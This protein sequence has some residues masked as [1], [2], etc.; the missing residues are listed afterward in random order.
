MAPIK[1]FLLGVFHFW[2]SCK[3]LSVFL[4]PARPEL[5]GYVLYPS[6]LSSTIQS[7]LWNYPGGGMT[8]F[9]FIVKMLAS[10]NGW[11]LLGSF[12]ISTTRGQEFR[13][14]STS[15]ISMRR[16]SLSRLFPCIF[17]IDARITCTEI[18]LS[19]TPLIDLQLE[20]FCVILSNLHQYPP[21]KICSLKEVLE[22]GPHFT[23]S[24]QY[25]NS[26]MLIPKFKNLLPTYFT[27]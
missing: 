24:P 20:G 1:K 5:T 13:I 15:V 14:P 21:W 17:N 19:Q 4:P 3:W 11:K 10:D 23:L 18:C 8:T 12:I 2:C 26:T 7:G 25:S 6:P 22:R 27:L 16:D 9:D